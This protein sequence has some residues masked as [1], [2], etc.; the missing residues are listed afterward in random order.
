MYGAGLTSFTGARLCSTDCD[1]YVAFSAVLSQNVAT[2]GSVIFDHLLVNHG[3]TYNPTD[4]LFTC[5]DNE[6][7][8]FTWSG[9]A[10]ARDS[11]PF[12]RLVFNST[13]IRQ[14]YMQRTDSNAD[15]RGTFGTCSQTAIIRCS[16]GITAYLYIIHR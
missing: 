2:V 12:L 11:D 16:T 3:N 10:I 14:A 5:P 4:G 6:L 15:S 13:I 1:D 7:Y 8:L 9:T